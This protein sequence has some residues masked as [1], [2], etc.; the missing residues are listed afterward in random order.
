[1]NRSEADL[2]LRKMENYQVVII[3][4][5]SVAPHVKNHLR[6]QVSTSLKTDPIANG[7]TTNSIIPHVRN[8]MRASKDNVYNL[9]MPQYDTLL[10][11]RALLVIFN[12]MKIISRQRGCHIVIDM[13]VY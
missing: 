8:V 6:R 4:S 9:K 7:I 13:R 10:V 5:A 1:M 11:L 3:N 2:S 12:L